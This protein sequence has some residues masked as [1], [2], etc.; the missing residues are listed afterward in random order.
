MASNRHGRGRTCSARRRLIAAIALCAG[1]LLA[2]GAGYRI[3]GAYLD[4]PTGSEPLPPGGLA[5][6]PLRLGEWVGQDVKVD[7]RIIRASDSDAVLSRSYTRR[8]SQESVGLFVAYGIHGR[9]LM[10][11][12]PEVCYPGAGYRLDGRRAIQLKLPDGSRLACMLYHFSRSG[13]GSRPVVVLHYY[14]VDGVRYPDVD[15]IR[16]KICWRG[17]RYFARV[18]I[19]C[20]ADSLDSI[21]LGERSVCDFAVAAAGAIGKLLPKTQLAPAD[22]SAGPSD[23]RISSRP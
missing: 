13:L 19:T 17:Y 7:E 20:N 16:W 22:G 9:D 1:V 11:H 5:N 8:F 21:K 15:E 6:L 3:L 18:M 2:S 23:T 4:R 10:P 14:I 12:R